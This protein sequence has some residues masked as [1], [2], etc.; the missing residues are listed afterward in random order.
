MFEE[1]LWVVCSLFAAI[2][3]AGTFLAN[4]YYKLPGHH[5]VLVMRIFILIGMLP[6]MGMIAWPS[7]IDFYIAVSATAILA[8]LGDIRIHNI[9][10]MHGGGVTARLQPTM[11]WVAFVLWIVVE[12]SMLEKYLNEPI[13]AAGIIASLIACVYFATRLKKC[14]VSRDVFFKILPAVI[15]F[16]VNMVLAKYALDRSDLHGGVFAYMV[17]QCLAAIPV[18]IIAEQYTARANKDPNRP[19]LFAID[20]RACFKPGVVLAGLWI[21]HMIAKNYGNSF[22]ENPAYVAAVILTAPVFIALYYKLVKHEESGD[23]SS[24]FGIV[25]STIIL[26]IFTLG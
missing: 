24:G 5:L 18:L 25:L 9:T 22:A 8:A 10:A 1:S 19:H 13:K 21:A 17:V 3:A 14:H 20:W 15:G 16:G 7:N 26:T 12:P 23:V 2:F 4:Q 6:F 11:I